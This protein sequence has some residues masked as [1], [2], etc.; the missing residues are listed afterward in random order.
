[1]V[2]VAALY[3]GWRFAA[4]RWRATIGRRRD[5][6]RRL[7]LLAIG[8]Y[9][10]LL[11][12]TFGQPALAGP[13]AGGGEVLRFREPY[14]WV[15]VIMQDDAV[16]AFSI[17]I[18]SRRF[19]Y[20]LDSLT[21][22]QMSGKLGRDPL[23]SFGEP[24]FGGQE[25]AIGAR[26]VWYREMHYFGNP[27]MYQHYVL[28][29]ND[30]GVGYAQVS[31]PTSRGCS[32][33]FADQPFAHELQHATQ[34]QMSTYRSLAVPNTFSVLPQTGGALAAMARTVEADRDEVRVF[35]RPMPPRLRRARWRLTRSLRSVRARVALRRATS[36]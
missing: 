32:G 12:Q 2:G 33:E 26:R 9:R 30:A 31:P 8:L 6:R 16:R 36:D 10:G 35:D 7:N 15:S 29:V 19:R 13:S 20:R 25:W 5:V 3:G 4:S 21:W 24:S 28:S 27:G 14:C 17:T 22:G 34:E 23:R 1:M 18:T 11:V